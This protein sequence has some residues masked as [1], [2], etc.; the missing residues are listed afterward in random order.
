MT[1]AATAVESRGRRVG[2]PRTRR[3]PAAFWAVAACHFV[4]RVGGFVQ[5]FLVLYLTQEHGVS[6]ATAGAVAAGVGAG[7]IA[8]EL[9]GGWL[10][11]L[12]GRRHTMLIG[13][14]GTAVGLVALG[15]ADTM[16]TI[17][18]AAVGLGLV[19]DL[20]RPAAMASVADLLGPA[21]RVRGYGLVFWAANLGFSVSTVS[22]GALAHFGYSLLFWLNAATSIVAALV[23]WR[24]I[25]ET[26]T[27][28]PVAARR[29]LLP[30]VMRDRL[31]VALVVVFVVYSALY[32]Q[33]FSTLPLAMA[34]DGLGTGTY[35]AVIALNGLVIVVAQPLA[36]RVL[37]AFDRGRMLGVAML[38]VGLGFGLGAVAHTGAAYATSVLVWTVGE[39]GVAV[40]FGATFADLAPADLRGGYLGLAGST[41]SIGSVFGPLA[42]TA[43]LDWAGGTT[44]WASCAVTGVALLAVQ[45]ALAP[46][47][48]RRHHRE[49]SGDG[50]VDAG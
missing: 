45:W 48:R 43:L 30:V 38:L 20:F 11:D 27:Q 50:V 14:V 39:I 5:P 16:P 41:W 21:D 18:M 40:M 15:S 32:L 49:I 7:S 9:L 31:L 1:V 42:G 8:S 28:R 2:Q 47:L 12:I 22:A 36:A 25:P 17:W 26:R 10:S 3:L 23:V 29:A 19:S 4:N 33:A 24:R 44:L 37:G 6:V 46:A 13:F 35:G 34:A